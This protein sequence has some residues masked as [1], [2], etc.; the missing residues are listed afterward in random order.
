MQIR[1]QDEDLEQA[2]HE[3]HRRAC[4][5]EGPLMYQFMELARLSAPVEPDEPLREVSGHDAGPDVAASDA[6]RRE[7]E[8]KER[9]QEALSLLMVLAFPLNSG[10]E[11]AVRNELN[12]VLD[13]GQ[14]IES[15]QMLAGD[16]KISLRRNLA[17]RPTKKQVELRN[18]LIE[19][20]PKRTEEDL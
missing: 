17:R 3:I 14:R 1:F 16:R 7:M 11:Q 20:L 5:Y 19:L 8:V 2:L 10:T 15:L 13:R 12:E 4:E 6:K 9:F 18:A